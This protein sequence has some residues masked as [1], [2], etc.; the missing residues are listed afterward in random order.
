MSEATA[1]PSDQEILDYEK[2][3]NAEYINADR[4]SSLEPLDSL[5][6]EYASGDGIFLNKVEVLF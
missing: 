5:V 6:P 4:I 1:R 2:T 3:I